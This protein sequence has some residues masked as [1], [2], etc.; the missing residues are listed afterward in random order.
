MHQ[1]QWLG[2]HPTRRFVVFW[3]HPF[4]KFLMLS[5]TTPRTPMPKP[6]WKA[7]K[8]KQSRCEP[9]PRPRKACLCAN[10]D[11]GR[12]GLIDDEGLQSVVETCYMLRDPQICLPHA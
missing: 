1:P 2:H 5:E 11:S 10:I 7:S 6:N 8:Y 9:E 3:R 4:D 12:Q